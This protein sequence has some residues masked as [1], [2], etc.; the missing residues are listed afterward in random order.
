MLTTIEEELDM[1]THTTL[2]ELDG[3]SITTEEELDMLMLLSRNIILLIE[4][5][6]L[7]HGTDG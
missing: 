3:L 2:Q 1:F 6:E 5:M 7:D 4:S